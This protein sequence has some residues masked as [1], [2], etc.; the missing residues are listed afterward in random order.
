MKSGGF[1]MKLIHTLKRFAAPAALLVALTVPSQAK[2]GK[3]NG[4]AYGTRQA[5]GLHKQD[6]WK[7]S[8]D[9]GRDDRDNDGDRDDYRDY[10][11]RNDRDRDDY[12]D[13]HHPTRTRTRRYYRNRGTRRYARPVRRTT[14]R[15]TSSTIH[16]TVINGRTRYYRIVNGRRVYLSRRPTST[17]GDGVRNYIHTTLR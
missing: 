8:N 16:S 6:N 2:P 5:P 1:T 7:N 12:R 4:H 14:R 10:R 15:N 13:N 9:R 3:G 11:N 17:L